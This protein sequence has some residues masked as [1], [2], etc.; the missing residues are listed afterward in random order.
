MK[1]VYANT[2]GSRKMY[3]FIMIFFKETSLNKQKTKKK[4]ARSEDHR[5]LNQN[6]IHYISAGSASRAFFSLVVAEFLIFMTSSK[7]D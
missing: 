7:I 4:Y 2:L 1:I 3:L 5:L 6:H